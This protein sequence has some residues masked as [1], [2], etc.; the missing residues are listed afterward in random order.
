M[1]Y[2]DEH[3][4]DL[5]NR[6]LRRLIAVAARRVQVVQGIHL[7]TDRSGERFR[8][9]LVEQRDAAEKALQD[10]DTGVGFRA[11]LDHLGWELYDISDQVDYDSET[12]T[13]FVGTRAQLNCRFP[14][15]GG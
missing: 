4:E 1:A 8:Q 15:H 11:V 7:S 5:P 6:E 13:D 3:H 9:H 2:K 12:Y 14:K 10:Y